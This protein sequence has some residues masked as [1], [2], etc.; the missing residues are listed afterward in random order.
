MPTIHE[1]KPYYMI[2]SLA[3]GLQIIELLAENKNMTVSE[4]ARLLGLSR[5]VMHR[6][7]AT[8]HRLGYVRQDN[9]SQYNLSMKLF[10]VGSRVVNHTE[11]LTIARPF[12]RDLVETHNETVNLGIMDRQETVVLDS[13]SGK[14][15]FNYYSAIGSRSP[16]YSCAVGK[17]I[18][19]F[20]DLKVQQAY[21]SNILFETQTPT[22]ITDPGA[23]IA[24]LEMIRREGY[25]IENEER[26]AGLKCV[27]SPVFDYTN[28]P[29]YAISIS[30]PTYRMTHEII[31]TMVWDLI[32][33]CRVIS[34]ELGSN[35]D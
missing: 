24:E 15:I 35:R 32:Q 18:L 12:M 28:E 34:K 30:G 4:S 3:R 25:A 31:A 23:F 11:I 16:A 1:E 6:F 19:A 21:V 10:E 5:I 27:A 8:L 13:L 9:R 2:S 20:S 33:S 22:T 7:L 29:T 17:V 14:E 26:T